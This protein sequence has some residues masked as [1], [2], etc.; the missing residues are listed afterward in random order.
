MQRIA[1]VDGLRSPFIKAW[2]SFNDVT[3]QKLGAFCCRQLL[4][5]TNIKA[6]QIDEVIFG[7]VAQPAEAANIA[8]VISLYAN[9]PVEKRA[10]T[11]SRNCASGFEAVSSAYEKIQ[12]GLDSVVLAGGSE[13]MSNI[14]FFFSKDTAKILLQLNKAKTFFAKLKTVSKIRP[15]HLKPIPG[16]FL[17]LSDPVCGLSMGQTAEILAKEY[18]I[19][20]QAQDEFSLA[21]HKKSI[22]AREKLREE[23]TPFMVGAPGF[24]N[25]ISDDNGPRENQTLE[26]LAKLKPYFERYTGT[27][28]AGNSSQITDG[29][30]ALLIMTEDKAKSLGYEP[31]GY[32]RA[33]TY[34]GLEPQ[35]MGLGP[36]YAIPEV[37]KKAELTL[38]DMDLIEINEAFAVQV[39]ASLKLLSTKSFIEENFS[40]HKDLAGFKM[41]KLNVN[42]GAVSL[43]HPVGSTGARMILTILKEMKRRNSKFGLASL[44]VGGGQGGAFI[45]ER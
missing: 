26:A 22:A 29:A 15:R 21:S 17:G 11:V 32:I 19:T 38:K 37:L 24:K 44:C 23:I 30:C 42:G 16:L 18:G 35:K 34:V 41:D 31:L 2:T 10:Y 9:I 36:A 33:Y 13:S 6:G 5:E 28:T 39:L 4:E 27:V 3:A 20:R 14:P 40:N 25:L 43:G 1:I 45:L 7:T 12:V 8:R